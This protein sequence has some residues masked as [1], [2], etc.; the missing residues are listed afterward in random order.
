M[1]LDNY[2]SKETKIIISCICGAIW[3]YFRKLENYKLLPNNRII[4][5]ILVIIWIY[6]NY[7]EPLMLPLGLVIM[8]IYSI[9]NPT[10]TVNL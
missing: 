5:C 7:Y 8:Y 6:L 1:L 4:S 3:I 9:I 10:L 2:I